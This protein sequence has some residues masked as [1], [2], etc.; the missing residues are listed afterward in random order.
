[1]EFYKSMRAKYSS[2]RENV[3][4][5]PRQFEA[6]LRIA[7][8]SAKAHLRNRVTIEDAEIA[9]RQITKF[10]RDVAIDLETGEIDAT[11]L[12][13]GKPGRKASRPEIVKRILEDLQRERNYEPIPK[14]EIID[15][16]IRDTNIKDA[17][18]IEGI[19]DRLESEGVIYQPSPGKYALVR[20]PYRK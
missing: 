2:E 1:M 18:V 19:L 6:F 17:A 3:P 13:T 20:M 4:I 15:R 12:Y 7:E 10:L 14:D 9:I 16:V 11:I 8:A 5:T